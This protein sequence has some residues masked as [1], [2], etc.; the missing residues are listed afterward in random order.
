MPSIEEIRAG[1]QKMR[2]EREKAV[3]G[4]LADIQKKINAIRD[5]RKNYRKHFLK[6]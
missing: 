3:K 1:I 5:Y 2:V 6:K 4:M